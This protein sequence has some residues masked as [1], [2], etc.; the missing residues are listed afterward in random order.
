M[1]WCNIVGRKMCG[2]LE[3][4]GDR[5]TALDVYIYVVL[6]ILITR[7]VTLSRLCLYFSLFPCH[8]MCRKAMV[9]STLSVTV[10][11]V[12]TIIVTT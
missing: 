12:F 1:E 6:N 10:I 7:S 4:R 11:F 9:L 5:N 8:W 3:P 2:V